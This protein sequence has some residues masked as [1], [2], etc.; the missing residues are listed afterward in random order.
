[1]S[2][3]AS[4]VAA[5]AIVGWY[6]IALAAEGPAVTD[7][8][9]AGP[10]FAVQGEYQG[11]MQID[12][13]TQK[14]G[15]QVIALGESKFDAVLSFGGLP[16]DGWKRGDRADRGSG[17][18]EGGATIIKANNGNGSA[19]IADGKVEITNSG[20]QTMGTLKKIDRQSPTLGAKPPAGAIVLF[21]GKNADEFP[22]AK[23]TADGLLGVPC[24]SKREFTDHTLHVEFRTPYMPQA[25]GQGRGNSGVYLQN[26]YE[27]QV[28][29]SFGLTGENNECGGLYSLKAPAV[30]MCLPPLSW[31]TYDMDFTAA[32]YEG[33]KKIKTARV[34]IK[35]NGVPIYD[36]TEIPSLTP[37]GAPSEAPGR[38]PLYMQDHGNPVVYRNIWVVEKK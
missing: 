36:D 3:C 2:R 4:L 1:M 9:K 13:R 8:A 31:Q 19:K 15:L 16:G 6:G 38:G 18:T 25:R 14:V 24:T 34:T 10:D 33:D 12:G 35:H 21:D 23:V 17:K 29:D 26:R 11:E 20:G 30:N 32:K 37:G 27:V 7:A 22:G 5:L 28:L